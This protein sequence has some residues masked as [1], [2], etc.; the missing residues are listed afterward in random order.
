MPIAEFCHKYKHLNTKRLMKNSHWLHMGFF[1]KNTSRYDVA[2]DHLTLMYVMEGKGSYIDN[3]GSQP[4]KPGSF[5]LRSPSNTHSIYRDPK[6]N[7]VEFFIILPKHF[8][9]FLNDSRYL[10]QMDSSLDIGINLS[11]LER[12][13]GLI[14]LT[15]NL[16]PSRDMQIYQEI[17]SF[18]G[19]INTK[20]LPVDVTPQSQQD[21]L[22]LSDF[23]DSQ[24]S[25]RLSNE[26]LAQKAGYG[27]ENF[28]KLFKEIIGCSPQDYVIRCRIRQAQKMLWE[29]KLNLQ[30]IALTLGYPDLASFSRQFKKF[31]GCA[32]S[33]YQKAQELI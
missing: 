20:L 24:S 21:M 33:K 32:P 27:V 7:W 4:L 3:K 9:D 26:E 23:I 15:N 8:Y 16:P 14:K 30:N 19:E 13:H 6:Q 5:L 12:I 31:C 2:K 11:W 29:N 17:I 25:L 18:F 28:R 10:P 22:T 1:C